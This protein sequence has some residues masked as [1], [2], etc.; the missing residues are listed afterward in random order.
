MVIMSRQKRRWDR[1]E[2]LEKIIERHKNLDY[3][4]FRKKVENIA[5][6]IVKVPAVCSVFG[7]GYP[8]YGDYDV[9]DRINK[10][11]SKDILKLVP[12][13][14]ILLVYDSDEYP[15]Y[16]DKIFWQKVNTDFSTTMGR[17]ARRWRELESR[18]KEHNVFIGE[19]P[20][21]ILD[22]FMEG[23][24]HMDVNAIP[25]DL[26]EDLPYL[27]K[28]ED[29]RLL[30]KIGVDILFTSVHLASRRGFS[31][32]RD[33]PSMVRENKLIDSLAHGERH[34]DELIKELMQKHPHYKLSKA[35]PEVLEHHRGIWLD[36]LKR[37]K[38]KG[39]VKEELGKLA[40]TESGK[41]YYEDLLNKRASVRR[42]WGLSI[43]R[44]K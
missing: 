14:D 42:K 9:V 10:S 40:L 25:R 30:D 7:V 22:K 12:D 29:I 13:V 4:E 37:L 16:M 35:Y 17:E 27:F 23:K 28:D 26:W 5:K 1:E 34:L 36:A 38:K 32:H 8:F 3:N 31:S 21:E 11:R 19:S 15:K 20:E 2:V 6:E 33:I 43:R 24:I 41:R 44:V 18:L 39:L